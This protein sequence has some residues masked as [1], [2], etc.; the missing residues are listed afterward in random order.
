MRPCFDFFRVYCFL[1]LDGAATKQQQQFWR[2]SAN[3]WKIKKESESKDVFRHDM[4]QHFRVS[5][6]IISSAFLWHNIW[7]YVPIW[8]NHISVTK[9]IKMLGN[10]GACLLL[11]SYGA[12]RVIDSPRRNESISLIPSYLVSIFF[13][14]LVFYWRQILRCSNRTFKKAGGGR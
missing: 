9:D 6:E 12:V 11:S 8:S 7:G 1:P 4:S 13:G 5:Q 10:L 14:F 3:P 2:A